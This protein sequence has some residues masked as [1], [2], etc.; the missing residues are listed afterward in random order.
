VISVTEYADPPQWAITETASGYLT[1]HYDAG[2]LWEDVKRSQELQ[3]LTYRNGAI[4]ATYT[5]VWREQE[6]FYTDRAVGYYIPSEQSLDIDEPWELEL[7]R[8][9]Y[10][11]PQE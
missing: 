1:E 7:A 10:Q 5:D 4:Y 2:V 11:Y 6:S 9:L 8:A 3:E